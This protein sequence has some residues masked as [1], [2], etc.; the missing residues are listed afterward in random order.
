VLST[1]FGSYDA[2][3]INAVQSRWFSLLDER[4]F[5]GSQSGRVVIDFLLHQDGRI[6]ALRVADSQVSDTL[7]WMCQRAIL[8]P[9]PYKPFP[10]DLRR[11]LNRDYRPVRFTFYYNR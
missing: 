10:P 11:M 6:T 4:D 2:A 3:F 7:S 5:V 9:A 8:D 1:P